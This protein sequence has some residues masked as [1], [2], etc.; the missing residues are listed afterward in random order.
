MR[1][2]F[3]PV[4]MMMLFLSSGSVSAIEKPKKT[5]T[6]EAVKLQI[7]LGDDLKGYVTGR[8]CDQCN[9]L[10]VNV[11]PDTK[12]FAGSLAVPLIEAKKRAGKEALVTFEEE[13]LKVVTIHW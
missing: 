5:Q 3:L 6:I 2:H 11:T 4:L 8:I 13:T 7:M 1:I 9:L 12:A 10:R